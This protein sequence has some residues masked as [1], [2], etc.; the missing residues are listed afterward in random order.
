MITLNLSDW[1]KSWGIYR[2]ICIVFI[3]EGNVYKFRDSSKNGYRF[4]K[5]Q[6]LR[7]DLDVSENELINMGKYYDL[8]K[9]DKKYS[10]N[11]ANSK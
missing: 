9:E 3:N 6:I 2:K 10:F 4:T 5:D 1:R 7:E 8:E 11:L